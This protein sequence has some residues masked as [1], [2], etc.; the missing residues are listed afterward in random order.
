MF[1]YLLFG[2]TV[3]V[4]FGLSVFV[5]QSAPSGSDQN[6]GWASSALVIIV[7]YGVC[8]LLLTFHIAANGGFNWISDAGII[9]NAMVAILWL[10]MVV[11]VAYC[12]LKPEYHKMY[13]LTGIAHLLSRIVSYGV[14]WLPLLMLIPYFF[15][16]K[17]EWRDTLTPI[18]FKSSLVFASVVGFLLPMIPKV[19]LKSYDKFDE[20]QLALNKAMYNIENQQD[21]ISL[22]YYTGKSYDEQIR[23]AALA[24]IKQSRK[25]ET[26]LID[27]L[28]QGSYPLNVFYFL[29]ENK[30]DHPERFTEP[31]IKAFSRII[32][33]MKEDIVNPYKDVGDVEVLLHVF[34]GQ[35]KD[36]IKTFIP[37]VVKLQEVLETPPAENRV[38]QD[39]EQ[40]NQT[41]I[42]NRKAVKNWLARHRVM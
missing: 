15:F 35:F 14:T 9:R 11:G 17:P 42:K 28:E 7:A 38:Y 6:Y 31:L 3:L 1:G 29:D 22:L 16:L 8:S 4:Y 21:I 23:H 30:I 36:S 27:I 34:E 32:E 20:H 5:M 24:K 12:T 2:F 40:S 19:M 33:D 13:Q 10:G 25:L 39:K 26:E 18:L 37:H 41:L